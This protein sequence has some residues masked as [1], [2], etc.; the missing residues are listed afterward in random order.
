MQRP[1]SMGLRTSAEEAALSGGGLGPYD[2]YLSRAHASSSATTPA[3]A[4]SGGYVSSATGH[5]AQQYREHLIRT[6]ENAM[7]RR[8]MS[9]IHP[10]EGLHER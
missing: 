5:M 4:A 7:R 8:G 6:P 9:D 2:A 10:I 3:P 1:K